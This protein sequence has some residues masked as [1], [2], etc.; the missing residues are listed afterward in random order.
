MTVWAKCRRRW[1]HSHQAYLLPGSPL[2]TSSWTKKHPQVSF[3]AAPRLIL[4]RR[5][6]SSGI[7]QLPQDVLGS[8]DKV[9]SFCPCQVG[10]GHLAAR[11][12]REFGIYVRTAMTWSRIQGDTL[13]TLHINIPTLERT[14]KPST[15]CLFRFCFVNASSEFTTVISPTSAPQRLRPPNSPLIC[16]DLFLVT[17]LGD[18]LSTKQPLP[19]SQ[20]ESH[21]RFMTRTTKP[22]FGYSHL[23]CSSARMSCHSHCHLYST[24]SRTL[25]LPRGLVDHFPPTLNL[26]SSMRG[27]ISDHPHALPGDRGDRTANRILACMCRPS[28]DLAASSVPFPLFKPFL[29][30]EVAKHL[31]HGTSHNIVDWNHNSIYP[32]SVT[33]HLIAF[34][35]RSPLLLP[36][37]IYHPTSPT[38][39]VL[40]QNTRSCIDLHLAQPQMQ[41]LPMLRRTS[42]PLSR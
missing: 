3:E 22:S 38:Q 15:P 26:A 17:F 30:L 33:F 5:L 9:G 6:P 1:P 34:R 21:W 16:F 36:L 10:Q 24:R 18:C 8:S 14:R 19:K 37:H 11:I 2:R 28:R 12:L 31:Y 27:N 25:P 39:S 35:C 23:S 41:Q 40:P 20:V 4:D 29:R 13:T 42:A 32:S 7:S